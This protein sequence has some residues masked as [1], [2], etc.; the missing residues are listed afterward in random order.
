MNNIEDWKS[1]KYRI[2]EEGIEYTFK[3]Y[4]DFKEIQDQE[5]HQKRLKLIESMSDIEEYIKNKI[6][7][8]NND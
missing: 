3:H 7:E 4:S 8:L 2:K 6:T 1:I 5:F